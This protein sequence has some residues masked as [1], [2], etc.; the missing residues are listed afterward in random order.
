M[1][2]HF[3]SPLGKHSSPVPFG[4]K[5]YS[6]RL[7][8]Y[9]VPYGEDQSIPAREY[10]SLVPFPLLSVPLRGKKETRLRLGNCSLDR[11]FTISCPLWGNTQ[12]LLGHKYSKLLSPFGG[13]M[14]RRLSLL[15]PIPQRGQGSE[16]ERSM[17]WKG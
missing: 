13:R 5:G 3:V 12:S 16:A 2:Q 9:F 15:S 10:I 6:L 17:T 7:V 11:C 1:L 4:R 14:D 8:S